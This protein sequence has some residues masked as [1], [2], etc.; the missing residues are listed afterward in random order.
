L[1][2]S[3][4]KMKGKKNLYKSYLEV[5]EKTTAFI[6]TGDYQAA[7]RSMALLREPVD[8]F[9][10]AVMVMAENEGVRHNRLAILKSITDLFHAIADFS[11]LNTA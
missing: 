1:I 5:R 3:S 11:K 8:A 6:K 7:L 4:L 2:R 9:F 10:T